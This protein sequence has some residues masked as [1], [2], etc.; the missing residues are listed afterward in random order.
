MELY[1]NESDFNTPEN[2]LKRE[3]LPAKGSAIVLKIR[4]DKGSLST[5]F[6]LSTSPD[7]GLLPF[8]GVIF[9]FSTGEG[10]YC[11]IISRSCCIPIF[12]VAEPQTT[13]INFLAIEPSLIPLSISSS[14]SS[15]PSRY[16]SSNASSNSAIFSTK[17]LRYSS[18]SD[19]ND[20]GIS[21]SEILPF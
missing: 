2:T 10:R 5:G 19:L 7:L 16:F 21:S 20:S 3:S 4:T 14:V 6:L 15:L 9:A 12:L 11:T 13:G 1:T 18:A 8:I 17:F